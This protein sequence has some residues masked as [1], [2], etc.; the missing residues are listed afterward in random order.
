MRASEGREMRHTRQNQK[1]HIK[2]CDDSVF[3]LNNHNK[4]MC[5]D[6]QHQIE[7]QC[8]HLVILLCKCACE[9]EHYGDI[10]SNAKSDY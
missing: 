8:V 6:K 9:Q 10:N 4:Y 2:L 1:A 3:M 5:K 7:Q